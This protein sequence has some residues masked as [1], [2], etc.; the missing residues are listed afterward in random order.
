MGV[1]F[2]DHVDGSSIYIDGEYR[3]HFYK[4]NKVYLMVLSGSVIYNDLERIFLKMK[5]LQNEIN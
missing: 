4:V 1:R 3:G 2:D 5:E